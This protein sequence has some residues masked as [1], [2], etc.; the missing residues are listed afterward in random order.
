MPDSEV[1]EDSVLYRQLAGLNANIA[2]KEDAAY[3]SMM[4][5]MQTPDTAQ[6]SPEQIDREIEATTSLLSLYFRGVVAQRVLSDRFPD[7]KPA[8]TYEDGNRLFHF[9]G[10]AEDDVRK[11]DEMKQRL[12][13][14]DEA[15][16][17]G[18][19]SGTP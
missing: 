1:Q 10:A 12:R 19:Q 15:V 9:Q 13:R 7:F 14:E 6:M 16:A 3:E 8:I 4:L 17:G 18:E 2:A 11:V 5:G